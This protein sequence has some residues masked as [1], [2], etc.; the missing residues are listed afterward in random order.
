MPAAAAPADVTAIPALAPTPRRAGA[1]RFGPG[2]VDDDAGA[3]R[4]LLARDA[5]WDG[6]LFVGVTSTGIYCRPVCRVRV[7]LA[8]NCRFFHTRAQAESA[9]FR[10][11]L[12]CRPEIAPGLSATDS[13]RALAD[14]AAAWLDDAVHQGRPAPMPQLARRLGITERHLRRIFQ[15]AHGVAPSE[16]LATQRLLLA[17]QLLTDTTQPV[18]A[19]AL[20][21]GFASLR[22]FNAAFAERYRLS[23]TA[24]R[25]ASAGAAAVAATVGRSGPGP[26]PLALR[27]AFRPPLDAPALLGFFARRAIPG[28][29]AVGAQGLRRTLALPHATGW[30]AGWVELQLD[31]PRCEV[32]VLASATLAAALPLLR[33]RVRQVLDLDADPGPVDTALQALQA[34]DLPPV[35]G[36]RRPGSW[37]GWETAARTVLGQQVTVAAARTLAQR[38]VQALGEPVV[39]PF[40]GLDRLF[41]RADVVA[42]ADPAH[43]G[44]LG[45]VRQRVR[46]LQ[47]L[48]AAVAD[49]S[50]D[51]HPGAPLQLTLRQLLALPG[52]GPWTAQVIALRALGWP[53]AW[54]AADIGLMKALG[55]RDP[56][57]IERLG[58]ALQ[59]WRSYATVR[60]WHHLETA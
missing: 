7:P 52:I 16:H 29:E 26:A 13:A 24:L 58:A 57:H 47:A 35:P 1:S 51:L 19:V 41:P 42:R 20:A 56:Q 39:T 6:R 45:I 9:G 43:L 23:P 30:L 40:P 60:L 49:G 15:A 12:K 3:Y 25:R 31:L 46:A 4:V 14:A 38:L 27:L 8:R 33:L 54:P 11:C 32:Q 34:L 21:S 55:S 48:A 50:L 2:T 44:A 36:L 53:D 5:R 18:T 28:V 10:P 17:K 37:C 59:P 22:R